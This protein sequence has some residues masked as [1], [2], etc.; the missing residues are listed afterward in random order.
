MI[1][2]VGIFYEEMLVFTFSKYYLLHSEHR[3]TS[4]LV[5]RTQSQLIATPTADTGEVLLAASVFVEKQ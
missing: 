4:P 5:P 2:L 1:V 3:Q